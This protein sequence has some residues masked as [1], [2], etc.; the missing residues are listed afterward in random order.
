[1]AA[2]EEDH[3][4]APLIF[5]HLKHEEQHAR[6]LRRMGKR[7]QKAL[8]QRAR[9]G[10]EILLARKVSDDLLLAFAVLVKCPRLLIRTLAALLD[11]RE[12]VFARLA[13]KR[14]LRRRKKRRARRVENMKRRLVDRGHIAP[15]FGERP[16]SLW[17][18]PLSSIIILSE[19]LSIAYRKKKDFQSSTGNYNK[20]VFSAERTAESGRSWIRPTH[21]TAIPGNGRD[22]AME[23]EH[24]TTGRKVYLGNHSIEYEAFIAEPRLIEVDPMEWQKYMSEQAKRRLKKAEAKARKKAEAEE[25]ARRA[26]EEERKREEEAAARAAAEE[27]ASAEESP[28]DIAARIAGDRTQAQED[29]LDIAKHT[30]EEEPQAED[31]ASRI[32]RE[33]RERQAALLDLAKQQQQLAAKRNR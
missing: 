26:E 22:Y 13:R 28:E 8:C 5:V 14:Q 1:M 15:P 10:E 21:D 6:R 18:P 19:N 29:I 4:L 31:V 24:V 2:A 32:E 16:E 30:V 9:K 33:R 7:T 20:R 17:S 3:K 12:K 27:S 25:A 11:V 23:K